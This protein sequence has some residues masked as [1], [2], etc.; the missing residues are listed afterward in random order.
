M[1][2]CYGELNMDEAATDALLTQLIAWGLVEERDGDIGP[3]RRW[4]A[5]VQA[6]AERINLEVA[7]TGTCPPGNPLVLAVATAMREERPDLVGADLDDAVRML[8]TLEISRM[9][10]ELKARYGF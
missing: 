5:R 10:P 3:T 7:K 1:Q 9:T 2:T 8:V 4:N 6:A